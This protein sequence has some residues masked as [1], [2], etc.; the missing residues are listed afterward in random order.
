MRSRAT[1]PYSLH[2]MD[3]G[4]AVFSMA[5]SDA[6]PKYGQ[7]VIFTDMGLLQIRACHEAL[8]CKKPLS[9]KILNVKNV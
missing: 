6:Y 8:I 1:F 3:V 2:V 9:V 5:L 4:L 7:R